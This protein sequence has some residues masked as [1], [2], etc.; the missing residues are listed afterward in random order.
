M[1]KEKEYLSA[2]MFDCARIIQEQV[3]IYLET[4]E[5]NESRRICRIMRDR[6]D[7]VVEATYRQLWTRVPGERGQL[8]NA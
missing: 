5:S 7:T 4:K 1:V 6:A 2:M 3:Q 8:L